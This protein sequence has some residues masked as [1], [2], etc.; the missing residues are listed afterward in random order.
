VFAFLVVVLFLFHSLTVTVTDEVVRAAF[1]PG[2]LGKTVRVDE[3]VDA[4]D[5][6]N[7]WWYG[8]GIRLTPHGWLY[9]VSGFDAVEIRLATGTRVRIGTDEPVALARAVRAAA[10]LPSS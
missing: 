10:G 4:T 3:I 1:G 5:V 8:W 2:L 9:N 6:R 7:R